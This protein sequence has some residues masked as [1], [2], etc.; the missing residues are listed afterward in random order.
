MGRGWKYEGRLRSVG[1]DGRVG[2][3]MDA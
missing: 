2:C 3:E 1:F